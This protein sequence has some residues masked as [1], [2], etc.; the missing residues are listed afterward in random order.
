MTLRSYP[1]QAGDDQRRSG[2]GQRRMRPGATVK[3]AAP[4][5]RPVLAADL[6]QPGGDL[7]QRDHQPPHRHLRPYRPATRGRRS[8]TGVVIERQPH[9]R[10]RPAAGDQP[11]PRHLH[12]RRQRDGDPRQP[13]LRQRRPRGAAVSAEPRAPGDR[14]RD[15]PQRPGRD[16]RRRSPTTAW[17]TD[18]IISNSAPAPQRRVVGVDRRQ[19]RRQ[20]QLPLVRRRTATTG[21]SPPRSGIAPDHLGIQASATNTIADPRFVDRRDFRPARGSPCAAMGPGPNARIP[22]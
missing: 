14:Q 11:R 19:Q 8:P 16:L 3:Q 9:P 4:G 22:R 12:R 7:R 13:D 15:R 5:Q 2:A 18:N 17:S 20:R 21:A 10:L 6:R 1:G